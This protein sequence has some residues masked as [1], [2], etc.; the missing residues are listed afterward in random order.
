MW[1]SGWR[2]F[3]LRFAALCTAPT[4]LRRS[5]ISRPIS[6]PI[7]SFTWSR[8]SGCHAA[9]SRPVAAAAAENA[10]YDLTGPEALS[11]GATVERLSTL[12]GR[13]IRYVPETREEALDQTREAILGYLEAAAKEG[14]S[15]PEAPAEPEILELEVA[16][17]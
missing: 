12:T 16:V 2:T 4:P 8:S 9:R 13:T 1:C 11:L 3:F 7:F 15:V 6:S 17:P 14:L 10:T 5:Y